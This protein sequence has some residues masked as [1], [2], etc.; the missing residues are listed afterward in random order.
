MDVMDRFVE[1]F[2]CAQGTT[3]Q[4]RAI[5]KVKNYERI[6][7]E[8]H[9]HIIREQARLNEVKMLNT[10]RHHLQTMLGELEEKQEKLER[11]IRELDHLFRTKEDISCEDITE[12]ER[13]NRFLDE[14]KGSQAYLDDVMQKKAEIK[15]EIERLTWKR[16]RLTNSYGRSEKAFDQL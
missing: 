5:D 8:K 9:R 12:V 7:E 13:L 3:I 4:Q 15:K 11:R 2:K 16:E 14:L 6:L 1:Q 10:E